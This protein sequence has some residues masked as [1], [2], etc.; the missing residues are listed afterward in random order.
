MV[1]IVSLLLLCVWTFQTLPELLHYWAHRGLE[2]TEHTDIQNEGTQ[3][4]APHIH[5]KKTNPF[6]G[7]QHLHAAPEIARPV[8][9]Q[10]AFLTVWEDDE[11]KDCIN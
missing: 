2:H 10:I 7:L 3:I 8:I 6:T 1:R 4:D 5:C 11:I 9:Y